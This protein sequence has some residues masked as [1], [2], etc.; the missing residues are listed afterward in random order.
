MKIFLLQNVAKLGLRGEVKEVSD[1]YAR[2][3]LFP[4]NL[5]KPASEAMALHIAKTAKEK[6]EKKKQR[7][8]QV[9]SAIREFS[10]ILT[11]SR[12]AGGETLFGSVSA[13]DISAELSKLGL[14]VTEKNIDL[15][16]PIKHLGQHQVGIVLNGKRVK[17]VAV[18]V[19][20]V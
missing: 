17:E 20:N 3:F 1:G 4:Q 12:P 15:P 10:Q 9:E 14:S 7:A 5:A 11:F 8:S 6:G 2:N 19:V 13:K 18:R 16:H